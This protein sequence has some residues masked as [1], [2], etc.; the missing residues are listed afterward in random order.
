MQ[1]NGWE[2]FA[3][4]S[5]PRPARQADGGGREGEDEEAEDLP[6]HRQLQAARG[7]PRAD[8]RHHPRRP[9]PTRLP[10]RSHA[11]RRHA[12]WFRAKFGAQRFRLFF[13][14]DSKA[15]VILYAW[16]NDE[17]LEANLRLED[18]RLR[19]LPED[20]RQGQ[21]SRRLGETPAQGGQGPRRRRSTR[22]GAAPET[23]RT[24]T[25]KAET[26]TQLFD[27]R[28]QPP[29]DH[30][31]HRVSERLRRHFPARPARRGLGRSGERIPRHGSRLADVHAA[32][33]TRGRRP[34]LVHQRAWLASIVMVFDVQ[35]VPTPLSGDFRRLMLYD[36]PGP[37]ELLVI[38]PDGRRTGFDPAL[39][40]SVRE[41]DSSSLQRRKPEP[42]VAERPG[43]GRCSPAR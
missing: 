22:E 4:A 13:R 30:R 34:R 10:A 7:S 8:V 26:P 1:V 19:R 36:D 12:H 33:S 17:R 42:R 11:G 24:V 32:G 29:A 5:P 16:V 25:R 2:L 23:K 3:H 40:R 18:R 35:T 28:H 14:Y 21:P 20:A 15:K 39:S 31:R 43:D 9:D 27:S 6:E 38:A 37:I 41:V